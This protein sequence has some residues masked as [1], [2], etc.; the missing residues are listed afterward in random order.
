[1]FTP[2]QA[3]QPEEKVI[4]YILFYI[5]YRMSIEVKPEHLE[6]VNK[7]GSLVEGSNTDDIVR[8]IDKFNK[9]NSWEKLRQ[10]FNKFSEKDKMALYKNGSPTLF[11]LS[12]G[13]WLY[14]QAKA[15][16][17]YESG[18]LKATGKEMSLVYRF[19]VHMN[20]LDNPGIPK[21]EL[22]QNIKE[23][24]KNTRVFMNVL[25]G[26]IA[27]VAPEALELVT[28]LKA[29]VK[30]L[31][32]KAEEIAQKQTKEN[33]ETIVENQTKKDLQQSFDTISSAKAA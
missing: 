8:Y 25:Q 13:Q 12:V 15:L 26:V 30:T 11:N 3:G 24:A 22:M 33:P 9:S 21:E 27:V 32:V 17:A 10:A 19:L 29:V 31:S 5:Q 4:N 14:G 20:I 16:F 7:V 1:M 28:S 6:A 2:H 23:D 18:K